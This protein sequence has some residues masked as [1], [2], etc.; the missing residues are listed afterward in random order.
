MKKKILTTSTVLAAMVGLVQMAG[1]KGEK[2]TPLD[3]L[4][5][6]QRQEISARIQEL[7]K[8]TEVD[9]D[10]IMVGINEKEEIAFRLR[11][12]FRTYSAGNFSCLAGIAIYEVEKP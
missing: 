11:S 9:W 7:T 4:S 12:D 2:F 1:A 5:P 8:N 6:E 10:N 3:E